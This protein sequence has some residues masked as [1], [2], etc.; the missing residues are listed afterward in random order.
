MDTH[1]SLENENGGWRSVEKYA[2][3]LM[4]PDLISWSHPICHSYL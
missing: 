4:H 2:A 1:Q 3:A